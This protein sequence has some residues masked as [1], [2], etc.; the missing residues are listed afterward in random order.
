MAMQRSHSTS[1]HYRPREI[2]APVKLSIKQLNQG[3]SKPL[4]IREDKDR[5]QI[6]KSIQ[7]NYLRANG[8]FVPHDPLL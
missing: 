8:I 6:E 4:G 1:Q 5:E 7:I 2:F 3:P